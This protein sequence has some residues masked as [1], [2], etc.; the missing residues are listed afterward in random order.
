MFIQL[1][2][3]PSLIYSA[4]NANANANVGNS[5]HLLRVEPSSGGDSLFRR[6]HV[7]FININNNKTFY[8]CGA[9]KSKQ[10]TLHGKNKRQ[11]QH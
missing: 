9:L 5:W 8:L 3:K 6:N 7:I 4:T 11:N 2:G 10:G 1:P